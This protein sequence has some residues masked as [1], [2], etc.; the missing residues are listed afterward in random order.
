MTDFTHLIR[1][2]VHPLS[3]QKL[4]FIFIL[5]IL[6]I[7]CAQQGVRP[8]LEG[9]QEKQ[10]QAQQA[11]DSGDYYQAIEL[12]SQLASET[13][14]PQ[15]YEYQ[16]RT[17][18]AMFH[19]GLSRQA[20]QTLEAMPYAELSPVLK[21]EHQLLSA[22]VVLKRDPEQSL[23]LLQ[24][25]AVPEQ[26][27]PEQMALYARYHLLRARALGRLG[28][29]LESGREYI[30]RELYLTETSELEANQ[31][32]IWQSLSMLSP[33]TL[34]QTRLAPPPDALSGWLELIKIAKNYS[35]TPGEV[36]QRI[37]NWRLRYPNHPASEEV[38]NQLYERSKELSTRPGNIALLL[39][40]SG[41]FAA[42]GES[43]LDGIFAAY[44]QDPMRNE[45]HLKVYDIG[46]SP[47]QV[48]S[49][50][51]QAMSEGAEFVIGP[52][53]KAAVGQLA[54]QQSLPVPTLALNY[55]GN[56]ANDNLYQ[57]SLAPED[58]ARAVAER[59]WLEGYVQAAVMVPNSP[60]GQRL[61]EAFSQRWQQ[62]G[63]LVVADNQYNA[64]NNDFS[65][66]IKKLLNINDSEFRRN[67]VQQLLRTHVEFTPR[68]RQDID[69]IFLAA[70]PQQAR[71]MRPQ[72][73]FFHAG[74]V[75]ILATSHLYSGEVDPN[76]DRDMN[77]IQFCDMPWTLNGPGP[78]QQLRNSPALEIH[79]GQLQRLVALGIDAYQMV[80]LVPMLA[81]HPYERYRGETGSLHIDA[82]H[83]VLRQ[84]LWA[85]FMRGKPTLVEER[86]MDD[87]Q[88]GWQATN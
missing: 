42:A 5:S 86:V 62:L 45:I 28:K 61:N 87:A 31:L 77:D 17:A 49:S 25:P 37:N 78:E 4:L 38:L 16:Y 53:D 82:R 29:H 11:L 13:P 66:A 57:F 50:Y 55:A 36:E 19:A 79:K 63:G 54:Q 2:I 3:M 74:D 69:F 46:E 44:Y 70:F 12:Y 59:A 41:R 52:L 14:A 58:E 56:A 72:F 60:L 1:D 73:K 34:Q 68:R 18:L 15:R 30:L 10:A 39:P 83:R 43:I 32:A 20:A 85:R 76:A 88:S 33:E 8:S 27:L 47:E 71:L 26:Q 75:P 9:P 21:L 64:S 48:M 81:S 22:E 65:A 23:A 40:L 67:R 24:K 35:L 51:R 80:S 84:L 7:G 6:L